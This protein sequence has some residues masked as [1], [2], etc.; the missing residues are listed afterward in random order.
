MEN[1]KM[2]NDVFSCSITDKVPKVAVGETVLPSTEC[3]HSSLVAVENENAT[4]VNHPQSGG[5]TR[6]EETRDDGK[7]LL[8]GPVL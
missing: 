6:D 4:V 1:K 3:I 2:L 8:L 5:C 7:L